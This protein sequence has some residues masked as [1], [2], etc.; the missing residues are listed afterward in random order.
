M[1]EKVFYINDIGSVRFRKNKRS[2]NV[3]IAIRPI[4][5]VVVSL[6]Y[7]LS[8]KF[9][10]KIVEKKKE[11]ILKNL[12]KIYE[13]ENKSTVFTEKTTFNTRYRK[14]VIIKDEI[15]IVKT[16][17]TPD[18]VI[19]KYPGMIDVKNSKIQELVK[20][21]LI[22]ILREEAKQYL[23]ERTK[24]LSEKYR[25]KYNSIFIKNN[26]TLWGSCSGINNINFNLHL[27]R[28][29]DHLIDYVIIHELCHTVEKN[30]G[31]R[32]WKLVDSICG[33]AKKLSKEL[34]NYSI[35]IY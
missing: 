14:L 18:S 33:D 28:L 34:K 9:A 29:P 3:S 4:K 30:H 2:K 31:I 1:S 17:I 5:G 6:P 24:E 16:K 27:L 10:V 20:K 23:P 26:K 21:T 19:I 32:F 13:I 25:F 22:K 12:P 15:D 8:Y 7:Y 35:Q 11:W